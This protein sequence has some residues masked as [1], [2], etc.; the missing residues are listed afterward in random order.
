MIGKMRKMNNIS[1]LYESNL[2]FKRFVN[3][4]SRKHNLSVNQSL[5]IQIAIEKA[6]TYEEIKEV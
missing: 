3:D 6:K 1:E 2:D 4:F 5:E